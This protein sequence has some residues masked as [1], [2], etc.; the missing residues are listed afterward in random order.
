M[1]R[2]RRKRRNKTKQKRPGVKPETVEIAN[3]KEHIGKTQN[4][5]RFLPICSCFDTIIAL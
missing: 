1:R 3:Y 4:N 5:F 2:K